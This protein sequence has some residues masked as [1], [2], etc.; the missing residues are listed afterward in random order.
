MTCPLHNPFRAVPPPPEMPG[1]T[2]EPISWQHGWDAGYRAA[3]ATLTVPVGQAEE[4][5]RQT[6]RRRMAG[7]LEENTNLSPPSPGT[8]NTWSCSSASCSGWGPEATITRQPGASV[9]GQKG[10]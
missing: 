9:T 5:I 3:L 10:T 4:F 1:L 6:E 8:R 2:G 7:L